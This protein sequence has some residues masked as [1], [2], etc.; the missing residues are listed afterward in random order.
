MRR[1]A[2]GPDEAKRILR[3]RAQEQAALLV[4]RPGYPIYGLSAP[5]LG[6][7]QVSQCSS[8]GQ[9]TSVTLSY[10]PL[11]DQAGPRVTV[12]TAVRGN[13]T[14]ASRSGSQ[15]PPDAE[16]RQDAENVTVTVATWAVAMDTVRTAPVPDLRP[17]I[18]AALEATIAYIDRRLREHKPPPPLDLPPAEGVAALRALTDFTMTTTRD[19]RASA[20]AGHGLRHGPD[21][22]RVHNALWQ[23]AVRERQRLGG[24]SH[25]AAD[26]DVT[27]AVNHLGQLVQHAPWFEAD[28]R[29][30]E[31]AVDE[32]LRHTLSGETVPSL[33]AQQAWTAYWSAHRSG[34]GQA[35]SHEEMLARFETLESLLAD[36][37]AAWTDWTATM[38]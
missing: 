32:T 3:E 18:E 10:G 29:L 17:V 36:W 14:A 8:N 37:L 35:A 7:V 34:L 24:V 21:W 2:G 20:R 4:P 13:G 30:R 5:A 22:G 27:S 6:P 9:W 23:R 31:A 33:R 25:E 26:A 38:G 28:P 15:R 12:T 16:S 19:I 1:V 11:D